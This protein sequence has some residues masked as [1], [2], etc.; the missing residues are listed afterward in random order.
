MPHE[1][2]PEGWGTSE[3]GDASKPHGVTP[4]TIRRWADITTYTED[5]SP[6][7]GPILED[8]ETPLGEIISL[9]LRNRELTAI[10]EI[11]R[12]LIAPFHLGQFIYEIITTCCRVMKTEAGSCLLQEAGTGKLH[13]FWVRGSGADKVREY[14]LEKGKGIAGWSAETGRSALVNDA[15][16]DP[17]FFP[18]VDEKTGFETRSI[19]CAP[20]IG[21]EGVIGVVEVLNKKDG[22]DFGAADLAFLEVLCAEI[23]V[24]IESFRAR[25]T[26]QK[27]DR[28][29]L[30]GAMAS[31]IIHDLK[32]PMTIIKGHTYLISKEHPVVARSCSHINDEIDR[33]A[34][35]AEEILGVAGG[36]CRVEQEPTPV[37]EFIDQFADF[38]SAR[39]HLGNITLRVENRYDGEAPLDSKRMRRALL[40][41]VT[42]AIDA[43]PE[44]GGSIEITSEEIGN[45]VEISVRDNGSGIPEELLE[46]LFDPFHTSTTAGGTGLGLAIVKNIVEAHRGRLAI[47]SAPDQGTTVRIVLPLGAIPR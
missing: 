46:S 42:N 10:R 28:M 17:R 29:A 21:R 37:A 5:D 33:L 26:A 45:E 39:L 38:V 30:V 13:F 15:A 20:V 12:S 25:E 34:E 27:K 47:E 41:I 4:D 44:S 1:E 36:S 40:N 14:I 11:T 23:A 24:A 7:E 22:S 18:G 6:T 8:P 3:E 31:S 19:L 2:K 35:L 16:S 9:R 43:I 32:N